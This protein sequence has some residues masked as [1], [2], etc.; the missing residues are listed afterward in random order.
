MW[1]KEKKLPSEELKGLTFAGVRG[2]FRPA[3][4]SEEARLAVLAVAALC[5]VAAAVTH[6]AA[7][8][9]RREPQSATEVTAPGM[10]V[11]LALWV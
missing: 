1:G 10:T 8:P 4:V 6:A 3:G 5:V 9:P 2:S 7:P 11:A